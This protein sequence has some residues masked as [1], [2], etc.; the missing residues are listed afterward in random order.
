M[1]NSQEQRQPSLRRRFLSVPTAISFVIVGAM[2]VL[3]ATRFEVD[4]KRTR[5]VIQ[6]SNGWW[7]GLAVA[8]HYSTFLFRGARW[9][10]LL[11]ER[12]QGRRA[13]PTTSVHSLLRDDHPDQLVRQLGHVVPGWVTPIGPTP[14]RRTLVRASRGPWERWWRTGWW[15]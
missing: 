15:T 14:T 5:D 10:L 7:A 11:G 3:L 8:V 1:T 13:S 6:H 2:V 12:H 4:W 9:R